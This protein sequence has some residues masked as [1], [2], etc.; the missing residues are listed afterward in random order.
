[1]HPFLHLRFNRI[2]DDTNLP[3][4]LILDFHLMQNYENLKYKT[5]F[6]LGNSQA[7]Y[8]QILFRLL[9][10]YKVYMGQVL[11]PFFFIMPELHP[12]SKQEKKDLKAKIIFFLLFIILHFLCYLLFPSHL[13]NRITKTYNSLNRE[14]KQINIFY[15]LGPLYH[16]I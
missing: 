9:N 6:F 11:C 5:T 13:S 16:Q 8:H 2:H 4:F 3:Y 1:M 7:F 15:Y 10:P 12:Y 14:I